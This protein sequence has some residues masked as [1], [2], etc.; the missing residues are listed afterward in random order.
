MRRA[1]FRRIIWRMCV[2]ICCSNSEN[3]CC[4]V[5][6][7]SNMTDFNET[8]LTQADNLEYLKAGTYVLFWDNSYSMMTGKALK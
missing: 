3:V 1:S 8:C 7:N 4:S 6:H 5:L 2:A